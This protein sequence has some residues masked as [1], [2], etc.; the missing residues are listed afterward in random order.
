MIGSYLE[1]MNRAAG[2]ADEMGSFLHDYL[3]EF[4]VVMEEGIVDE[5]EVYDYI[6]EQIQKLN[7]SEEKTNIITKIKKAQKYKGLISAPEVFGDI[8]KNI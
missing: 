5:N 4:E 3:K 7:D 8:L 1:I 2:M 6:L